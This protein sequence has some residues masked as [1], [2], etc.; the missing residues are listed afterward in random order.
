MSARPEAEPPAVDT[1]SDMPDEYFAAMYADDI[2]PWKFDSSWYERR[3]YQI[4]LALLSRPRY[5]RVLE[6]GC[7]NGSLTTLLADRCDELIAFDLHAGSVETAR[8]RVVERSHVTVRRERF[9]AF[10][11]DG[12]G[13]LVVWSE[14]AYYLGTDSARRAIDGLDTWLE[15]GGDLLAVHYTGPTNYPRPGAEIVPWLDQVE[16]LERQSRCVDTDFE[17][18]LWTRRG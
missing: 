16:W 14:V 9:P 6:P 5:R 17:A 12:T 1:G 2:D 13:D 18:A 7:S 11:P 8:A 4:S 15:I 10:W 3:K